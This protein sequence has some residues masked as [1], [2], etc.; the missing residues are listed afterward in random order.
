M[1]EDESGWHQHGR[2]ELDNHFS[3]SSTKHVLT[4]T[5][6][7]SIEMAAD[8]GTGRD[9]FAVVRRSKMCCP[10]IAA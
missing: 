5:N 8:N 2:C 9:A 3:M 4:K 10:R 6:R 1:V 7:I